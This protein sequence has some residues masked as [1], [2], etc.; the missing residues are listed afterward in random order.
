MTVPTFGTVA[1]RLVEQ[2]YEPVPIIPGQ[3]RPSADNWT[4]GGLGA[5][6]TQYYRDFTGILT[7]D[8]PAVDIDVSDAELVR[9]I[10]AIVLDVA[11]C[12]ERPPPARIGMAPRRLLMFR[13]EKPFG[14]MA[15][16][17]YALP[18]DPVVNGKRKV[19]K[20]EILA[21]GQ[22]FVA[23]AVHP[24]TRKPY[25]WNGGGDP[26]T[27]PVGRL[28]TLSHDQAKE[29][30]RRSD[31]LLAKHGKRVG[32]ARITQSDGK[33]PA[34][35]HFSNP[36]QRASDPEACRSA[37][38]AIPNDDVHFDDWIAMAHAVKA[39]LGDEGLPEFIAW[40]AKSK[41]HDETTTREKWNG[42]RSREHGPRRG[43]GS[44]FW[45]AQQ[46]GW[47]WPVGVSDFVAYMPM[48]QYIFIPNRQLWPAASVNARVPAPKGPDGEPVKP[49]AWLDRKAPVEQ[50]TWAPGEPMLIKDRLVAGGGWIERSGCTTFN[51][52]VPP[53]ANLGD[54]N[55]VAP[56][57]NHIVRVYGD[58]ADH[59]IDWLAHRV[60]HP[61]EKINHALV[62]GGS[63][64]IGKDTLLE[65][66]KH[67]VGPWNFTEAAPTHMM[68]RFNGYVKSVV[69]RV[70]EAR[71]LGDVDRYA[72]YD[73]MKTLTAAPPDVLR[74]DEKNIKE[75]A[76]M[77]VTGV[78]ITSNHK[79]DGIFLPS[80]DRRHYVAWSS[81][82]KDD[83]S[84]EYWR[85]LYAWYAAGGTA[86]V[87]AY[88]KE[89]DIS[90][91]DPKAPPV[92][93]E[94]WHEIVNANCAPEDA[95]LADVI[96]KL[97]HP[98]ALTIDTLIGGC[99]G[100]ITDI[101]LYLR[102]RRHRRA[103]PHRLETAGYVVVRNTTAADGLFK[104]AGKRQVVYA[105]RELSPRERLAAAGGLIKD[106]TR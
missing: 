43:A 5:K 76:V 73:H 58:C 33:E 26:L 93:T 27:V 3:K 75:Y 38:A 53:Q 15:T 98:D 59:I 7:R 91:F 68:G 2:G 82:S 24:D 79:S 42:L 32:G 105:R 21:D 57:V 106:A 20:V 34:G 22:Q 18:T 86:N 104:V 39:A 74:C 95:E 63:Q 35:E 11:D 12:H 89:R 44:I 85:N 9:Q 88:L 67:A 46:H 72:F 94:A 83:F 84:P 10:E 48:H 29:I 96:E 16:F 51:L 17:D 103:V 50:M 4:V 102:D 99:V 100:D 52:Y 45:L 71:D 49:S 19:S 55:D 25:I 23:F 65:P 14:K 1:P 31:E 56:W 80:D 30:I 13:T 101:S 97:G 60:Q 87:T 62:L 37:L 8:A 28:A 6:A 64:G 77:N 66:V 47:K 41:K 40:S 81:L 92:R 90:R 70:S 78:I 36:L 61:G 69:L 54:R